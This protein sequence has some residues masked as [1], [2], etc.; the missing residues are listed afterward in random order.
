MKIN[1]LADRLTWTAVDGTDT[2]ITRVDV[3]AD[4]GATGRLIWSYPNDAPKFLG[5]SMNATQLKAGKE[6]AAQINLARLNKA[7]SAFDIYHVLV[8]AGWNAITPA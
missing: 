1:I 4:N 8:Q 6:C 7:A 3:E 5:E 2:R